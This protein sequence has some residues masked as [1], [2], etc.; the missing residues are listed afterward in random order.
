MVYQDPTDNLV[1]KDHQGPQ[2][3]REIGEHLDSRVHPEHK[4]SQ[5]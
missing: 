1:L 3:L 2:V 4:V 5:V